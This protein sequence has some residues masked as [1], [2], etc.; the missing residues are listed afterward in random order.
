MLQ[1][2]QLDVLDAY[3]GPDALSARAELR[4][5]YDRTR[6]LEQRADELREL[7]GARER[8]LDLVSFELG[9]I[10][11]ADPSVEEEAALV[12]ERDRLRHLETLQGAAAG[13][14]GGDRPRD[15]SGDLRAAGA[16]R[17]PSWSGR[18]RSTP[19]CSGL[20]E[21]LAG[22]RYEADDI[23]GELRGYRDGLDR[24]GGGP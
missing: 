16:R 9:E 6:E 8:E 5:A 12:A 21:R 2:A 4:D 15:G 20:G 23:G 10:D 13:G 7:A 19:S 22:L 18:R 11:A 24:A 17:R 1:T 14:R 3:C